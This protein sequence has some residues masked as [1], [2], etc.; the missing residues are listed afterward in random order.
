MVIQVC[1]C[2][3]NGFSLIGEDVWT[4]FAS[5]RGP[6]VGV[7]ERT[8]AALRLHWECVLVRRGLGAPVSVCMFVY[9]PKQNPP[10]RERGRDVIESRSPPS[11]SLS[12]PPY[13]GTARPWGAGYIC[14]IGLCSC[15][16]F[17]SGQNATGN[18]K[19]EK[20]HSNTNLRILNEAQRGRDGSSV[21]GI[22]RLLLLCFDES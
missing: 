11:L 13:H 17:C 14:T 19:K 18:A 22:H 9:F 7:N 15:L 20:K 1:S 4:P 10:Y 16:L 8:H 21:P 2:F 5:R 3:I 6:R 12:V